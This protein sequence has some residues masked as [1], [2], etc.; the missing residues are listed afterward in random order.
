MGALTSV[1]ALRE[2]DDREGAQQ[3]LTFRL[4]DETFAMGILKIKE[5]LEFHGVSTVPMMPPAVRGV[6]N[7]RG[8]V[9]PVVDLSLRFGRA[10]IEPGKRTCIVILEVEGEEARQEVGVI[11]DG[12]NQVQEIAP[13]QI[14]PAPSFGARLPSA[15]IS[16]IGKVDGQ[17]VVLL[18]VD[19]VFAVDDMEAILP[20]AQISRLALEA[21]AGG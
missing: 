3:Y 17:F 15:F 18:N 20:P 11:V 6:I 16:G 12:V 19:R 2:D 21:V 8:R 5:I 13:D 9:V 4:G 1:T 10:A 14:E 7:L